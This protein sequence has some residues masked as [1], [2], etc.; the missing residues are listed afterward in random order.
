MSILLVDDFDEEREFLQLVLHKAGYGPVITAESGRQ[1]LDLLGITG[2]RIPPCN[3]DV[4]LMDLMMPDIDGLEA[5]RHIRSSERLELVPIIMI[6][7]KTDASDLQAAYTAGATDFLRKPI[8]PVELIARVSTALSL[9]QELD[10]RKVREQELL[11]KT[12]ELERALEE[13]KSLRGLI[14]ICAK[15]KRVRS[16]GTYRKRIEDYLEQ[17]FDRKLTRDICPDCLNEAYPKAG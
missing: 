7:A 9:K 12:E 8:T 14:A 6:T 3:P 11:I 4:I 2:R 1:A 13:L 17:C 10:A 16:D 5:C 15:C